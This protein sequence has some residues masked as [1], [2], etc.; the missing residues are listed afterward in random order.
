MNYAMNHSLRRLAPLVV[1]LLASSAGCSLGGGNKW[2][3]ASWDVR[4]AVGLKKD[5]KP[6]PEVPA[7]LASTWTEAVLN[8]AG[9]KPKRGFGG[10]LTFYNN[11]VQ[12]P[13]RVEGQLVV[14]A[15]DETNRKDY[16]TQPTRRYVFPAEQF[17]IYES[18]ND[19]G[20]SYSVWLPWDDAGGPQRKISLI[21]KFEP[22][23]GA[24]IVGEQTKHLLAGPVETMSLPTSPMLA[25]APP[26]GVVPASYQGAPAGF[27]LPTSASAPTESSILTPA[28]GGTGGALQT[29]TIELPKKLSAT[30]GS[31]RQN[32]EA[33]ATAFTPAALPGQAFATPHMP[34]VIHPGMTAE[35]ASPRGYAAP[36]GTTQ[37][38]SGAMTPQFAGLGA[39]TGGY[40]A[41]PT[42][43]PGR[44]LP[45]GPLPGQPQIGSVLQPSLPSVGYQSALSQVP[46]TPALR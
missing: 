39:P 30:P 37:S 10:R 41:P 42:Q 38:V 12:D 4:R 7:R 23:D 15:F 40:L 27:P 25:A 18:A 20:A 28:P 24:P 43:M 45:A 8:R 31:R 6:D 17:S 13:V 33:A 32:H 3:F 46:A 44:P 21:A 11:K 5:A 2:K 9:E 35:P 26:A 36:A 34:G 1:L 19:L 16:E 14:Y 29:T 22:K